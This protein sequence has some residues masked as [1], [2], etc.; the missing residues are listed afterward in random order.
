[1]AIKPSIRYSVDPKAIAS[2]VPSDIREYV[3]LV[4]LT[5]PFYTVICYS[6]DRNNSL[7]KVSQK[8]IERA[9]KRVSERKEPVIAIAHSFSCEAL[10]ILNQHKAI[11]I[12]SSDWVWS[13][14]SAPAL[15]PINQCFEGKPQA[16]RFSISMLRNRARSRRF[17]PLAM[18]REG[19]LP[20][21]VK[22]LLTIDYFSCSEPA[23]VKLRQE[24]LRGFVQ[25]VAQTQIQGWE[26]IQRAAVAQLEHSNP[27]MIDRAL[28]ILY[29]V[30]E[31]ENIPRV[32]QFLEHPHEQ[33]RKAARTCLFE[34][35]KRNQ[36]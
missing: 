12:R 16:R 24:C 19:E 11:V 7:S 28:S 10:A 29:I 33:V 17:V 2:H 30:G 23:H 14:E 18:C 25:R 6:G 34:L 3:K 21:E 9:L 1:M 15:G 20:R 26:I 35:Q 27:K 31:K 22:R 4:R 32:Q 36:S 5:H 8:S 13:E